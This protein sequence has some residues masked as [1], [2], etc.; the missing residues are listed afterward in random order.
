[1]K[2]QHASRVVAVLS[3]LVLFSEI[4]ASIAIADEAPAFSRRL[5]DSVAA[6]IAIPD[7]RALR[8]RL[9][10]CSWGRLLNDPLVADF[11]E[12]LV[13]Q[14]RASI[15]A[16]VQ[17]PD[18][19][20]AEDL[21]NLDVGEI[22]LTVLKPV[23]GNLPVV[24]SVDAAGAADTVSS[25]IEESVAASVKQG[26]TRSAIEHAGTSITVLTGGAASE[27]EAADSVRAVFQRDGHVVV[28]NSVDALKQVLDRW[29]GAVQG[30]FAAN[31]TLNQVQ[32]VTMKP[33][34]EPALFWYLDPVGATISILSQG[35]ASNP[36]AGMALSR[37]PKLGLTSFRGVGGTIDFATGA[38]DTVTR[39]AGV[40]KQP[41]SAAMALVQ[42]PP[43]NLTPPEWVP[44]DVNSC[45][46]LNWDAQTAYS[47]AE[48]MADE[49][50]GP[51]GLANALE[52]LST[53]TD[54][55]IHIK[56]DILDGITGE[57][58][59]LQGNAASNAGKDSATLLAVRLKD[60]KKFEGIVRQLIDQPGSKAGSRTVGAT[61]VAVYDGKKSSTHLA[62][63]HG[64]L[65]VSN[66]TVL[67]DKVINPDGGDH[68]VESAYYRQLSANIPAAKSLIAIQRPV[69]QLEVAYGILKTGGVAVPEGIDLKL[70][71]TFDRIQHHFLPTATWAAP[72]ADGFQ[73]VSFSLPPTK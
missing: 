31:P 21:L 13:G 35:A 14:I 24:F 52:V 8:E 6:H 54:P 37:L 51:G 50:L 41:V 39:I 71:P 38:H 47:G 72:T 12:N 65:L 16:S 55:P 36:T 63:A 28:A 15:D 66:D 32:Q 33:G 70:L 69:N 17:L 59:I 7:A 48:L 19:V 11:R 73:Y 27:A 67:L 9:P 10:N 1:M 3:T 23:D 61:T 34:R 4:A 29:G 26:W 2:N 18:G 56:N 20:S 5:P 40:V 53:K 64:V 42:F 44:N 43:A 62:V 45:M 25:L 22:T 58:M 49:F 60:P 46:M 30:A 68:L 57:V